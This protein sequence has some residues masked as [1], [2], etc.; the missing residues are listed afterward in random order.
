MTICLTST[1]VERLESIFKAL[2]QDGHVN[3]PFQKTSFSPGF[4]NV[5]DKLGVIF[6]IMTKIE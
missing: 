6:H 3:V 1:D 4:G 5:T 2:Q